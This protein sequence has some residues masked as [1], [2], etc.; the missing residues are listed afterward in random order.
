MSTTPPPVQVRSQGKAGLSSG[1]IVKLVVVGIIALLILTFILQNTDAV[2]FS[3]LFWDFGLAL[4]VMFV[5]TL[6]V[7]VL[8]GMAISGALR[9]R[10]KHDQRRRA[11]AL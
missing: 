6:V 2:Q 3:F 7:G 8:I 4:W 9:M 11:K 5:V 10:R 1:T